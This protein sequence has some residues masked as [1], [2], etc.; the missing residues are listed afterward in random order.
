M[1]F[2]LLVVM[3][4]GLVSCGSTTVKD[5]K[6]KLVDSLEKVTKSE[7]TKAYAGV[8]IE[9]YSC[10]QEVIEIGNN[11][12][13]EV[14]KFLKIQEMTSTLVG[15]ALIIPVCK[16]VGEKYLPKL[17]LGT[18]ENKYRCL[19]FIG[20]DGVKKIAGGLCSLIII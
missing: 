20:A 17:I 16:L 13:N 5:A 7:L 2:L 10:E 12:R 15:D 11:V 18:P 1:K 9:G 8:V 3:L 6:V 4:L 14:S 19:R